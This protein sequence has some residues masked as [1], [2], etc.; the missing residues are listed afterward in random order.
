MLPLVLQ[1]ICEN[2]NELGRE[3]RAQFKENSVLSF[4]IVL[5]KAQMTDCDPNSS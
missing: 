1:K 4:H 3:G 5:V 2:C